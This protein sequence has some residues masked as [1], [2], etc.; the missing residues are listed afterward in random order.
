MTSAV[1]L[2]AKLRARGIALE[3]DG[4]TLVVRPADAVRPEEIEALMQ[5]KAA[6]LALLRF[7]SPPRIALNLV[8]M[9]EAIGPDPDEHS[10]ARL[11]SDVLNAVQQLELEI[12]TSS[13]APRPLLVR[14]RPLG[15]WL[16]LSELARLLRCS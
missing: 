6:V 11:Q 1:E 15:D 12:A 10:V 7:S 14:G 5:H 13:I 8:V 9:Y 4:G 2:V 16:D 3:R